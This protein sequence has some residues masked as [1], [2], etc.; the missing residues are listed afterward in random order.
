MTLPRLPAELYDALRRLAS[1]ARR[2]VQRD[3]GITNTLL[4][5]LGFLAAGRHDF[6]GVYAADC[7]PAHLAS[8]AHF[9]IIV[10]LGERRRRLH[11]ARGPLPVGHFVAIV[12]TPRCVFYN[13]PYGRPCTQP[14]VLDF[15]ALCRRPVSMVLERVQSTSST[16]CGLF[17]LLFAL[18]FGRGGRRLINKGRPAFRL[19]FHRGTDRVLRKNDALCVVYLR[20]LS[21]LRY[22]D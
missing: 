13:D 11:A 16:F 9:S 12:G 21:H 6:Q 17:A 7:I 14:R 2:H 22:R 1:N 10:N 3:S 5:R 15:L 4:E 19:N 8:R 20:L 18:Y